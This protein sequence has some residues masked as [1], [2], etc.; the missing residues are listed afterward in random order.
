MVEWPT[1]R[2]EARAWS[3]SQRA[4]TKADR[5]LREI[6]VSLPPLIADLAVGI[7]SSLA[8]DIE[9]AVREIAA[10]DQAHGDDLHALRMLLLRTEAVASS[11]IEYISAD[12]D[13]YAK[14][15][16][17]SRANAA[18]TS[19]VAATTALEVFMAAVDRTGRLEGAAVLSAHGALMGEDTLERSY[20]GRL[21]DMQ[22]WIGGSDHS[23]RGA[24]YVPPPPDTV[25]GYMADVLAF[26]NRADLP[27]LV[28]AA[29]AHAQFESIHP[30]TDGNGRIGRALING[31]LRA[32]GVTTRVVVPLASALVAHRNRYFDHL[33]SYRDGDPAPLIG[34]F[35]RSARIAA[36]ESRETAVRLSGLPDEWRDAIG[37]VRAGS[38]AAKLLELL[39]ENPVLSTEDAVRLVG[40]AASSAY[41]AVER[42]A[43][44]GILRPLS[45]RQRNQIW[46]AGSI[47]DELDD[48]GVR[49]A[50]RA[51]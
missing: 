21:R 6:E 36:A 48:L 14:A 42:L 47:L 45:T 22:N 3:Q 34:S 4:G 7:D 46:G 25:P 8:R 23:P 40:G 39:P 32:R 31:V 27:A 24:L 2:V 35:A 18:A 17:G 16:H 41:A 10:L 9:S 13:D 20:A 12:L 11:K 29:I 44:A 51:R 26:A 28:Q 15:L 37:A 1:H 43:A 5:M 33:G 19:M 38:A 50:E 30:F 49:I